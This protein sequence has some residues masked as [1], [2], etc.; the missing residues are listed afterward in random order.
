MRS[1]FLSSNPHTAPLPTSTHLGKPPPPPPGLASCPIRQTPRAGCVRISGP[2][3]CLSL[4]CP[5][6][7]QHPRA[8]RAP[9]AWQ[10]PPLPGLPLTH[11]ILGTFPLHEL[12]VSLGTWPSGRGLSSPLPPCRAGVGLLGRVRGADGLSFF[13][14]K[15][16]QEWPQ[17]PIPESSLVPRRCTECLPGI[18]SGNSVPWH[19]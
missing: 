9:L 17:P 4:L 15:W 18:G 11:S 10:H 16:G 1:F 13:T 3:R 6:S 5:L 14:I 19:S 12:T 8:L 7:R 2:W